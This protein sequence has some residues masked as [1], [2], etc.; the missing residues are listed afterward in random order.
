MDVGLRQATPHPEVLF[1]V[2]GQDRY[3]RPGRV[4]L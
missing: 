1:H 2:N 3:Q 4:Q